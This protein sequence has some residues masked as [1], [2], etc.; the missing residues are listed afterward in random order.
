MTVQLELWHLITLL[1]TVLG[2]FMGFG[3]MLVEQF[4]RR[5]DGGF[6]KLEKQISA[7]QD[8][9]R[10]REREMHQMRTDL[11]QSFVRREDY[12]RGDAVTHAKIDALAT[13]IELVVERL[14]TRPNPP[15]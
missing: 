15:T 12:I 8:S 14:A 4:D 5:V 11:V 10:D 6:G 3:R 9:D 7:L 1:I 2:A 13:K